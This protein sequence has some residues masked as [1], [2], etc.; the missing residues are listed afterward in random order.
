[1]KGINLSN[2]VL[3]EVITN[4][5]KCVGCNKCMKECPMSYEVKDLPKDIMKSIKEEKSI[6]P[7]IPF[8]CTL[9]DNCTVKCPKD[10]SLSKMY[11][12]I[13][14]DI[15]KVDKETTKSFGYNV[16]KFHQ[17]SSYLNIFTGNNIPK[18]C[19]TVFFPG[20]SLSGYSNNIIESTYN[21][22]NDKIGN[23]GIF[24]SCCGKPS[25]DIGDKKSF[26]KNFQSISDVLDKHD[27]KEVIVACSNC[28]NTIKKYKD[29][30]VTTLW[31]VLRDIGVPDNVRGIYKDSSLDVTLHDPCPIRKESHIHESVRTIL[32][33]LGLNYKEFEQNKGN[34]QCCGAGGM[35]MSTNRSVAL[36]QMKNRA[37]QTDSGIIISYCESCVDS[38]MT[39]GKKGLH[40]LDFLFNENVINKSIDTQSPRGVLSH[41][42]ERRK[43]AVSTKKQ[44]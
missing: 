19:N 3:N 18:G 14:E 2:D 6:D 37:D 39:G 20:C 9:C 23:I 10:I 32:E 15:F 25:I 12:N 5:E 27:I 42:G 40:V 41:W 22:L 26:E 7:K 35:M 29:V 21:Y 13:R 8:S 11:K 4:E 31:E 44:K 38:M 43:T 30:K 16:V 1:M 28:F 33:E 36:E 34:T 24:V 17:K